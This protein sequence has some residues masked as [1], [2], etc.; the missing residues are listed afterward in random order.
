M[1]QRL[2]DE[3]PVTVQES[4]VS[5]TRMLKEMR[6]ELDVVLPHIRVDWDVCMDF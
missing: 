4:L 6:Y 5:I 3:E 1:H 2:V